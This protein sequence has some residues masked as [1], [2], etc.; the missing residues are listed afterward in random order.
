MSERQMALIIFMLYLYTVVGRIAYVLGKTKGEDEFLAFQR[1]MLGV[2]T[3]W[4]VG[5]DGKLYRQRQYED[6]I[7]ELGVE[8]DA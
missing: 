8:V 6:C 2:G 5:E 7:R 3:V 1:S 4:K